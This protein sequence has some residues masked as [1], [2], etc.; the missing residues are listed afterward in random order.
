MGGLLPVAADGFGAPRMP[1][2]EGEAM[3]MPAEAND[4]T[5]LDVLEMT[6]RLRLRYLGVAD[7]EI[8]EL[9]ALPVGKRPPWVAY[10]QGVEETI[11][12]MREGE[13]LAETTGIYQVGN[14]IVQ[15]IAHRYPAGRWVQAIAGRAQDNEIELRRELYID[16]DS[17]RPRGISATDAEKRPV[18]DVADALQEF[19]ATRI[20]VE[21]IARGDSGNGLAVHV[22]LV[23]FAPTAETDARIERLLKILAKKFGTKYVEIDTTVANRARL[24]PCY[25][26]LKKKGVDSPQRPHRRTRFS[27]RGT[28]VAVPLEVLA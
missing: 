15:A 21:P 19:L 23:P 26:S 14:R 9:C 24:G 6:A 3:T 25:G 5:E 13:C 22:R 18:Y 10:A 7:D 4:P 12:L 27:C 11:R 8:V 2:P 20:G 28:V 17:V 1:R 16:L